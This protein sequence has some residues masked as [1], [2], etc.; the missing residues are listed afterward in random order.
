MNEYI[1]AI[2]TEL[3]NKEPDNN[4]QI[5]VQ[6]NTAMAMLNGRQVGVVQAE[7]HNEMLQ[8][9]WAEVS[10]E[11]QRKGLG[12]AMYSELENAT[13]MKLTHGD[14][15]T[16]VGALKL[17]RKRLGE[18]E[19]W[20]LDLYVDGLYQS[21]GFLEDELGPDFTDEQAEQMARED[22]GIN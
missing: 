9:Q 20:M 16:S 11:H 19:Q 22:L 1:K 5:A 2:L 6:G 17:W 3:N 10:E 18:T 8:V 4:Y 14:I 12:S 13:G 7:E 15:R 21:D